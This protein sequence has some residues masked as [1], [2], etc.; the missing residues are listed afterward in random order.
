MPIDPVC[1]RDVSIANAAAS[2]D[3]HGETMYFCS[4]NC[5]HLFEQDPAE[6]M[7]DMSDEERIA[8]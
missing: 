1:K 2:H 8:S 5:L 3:F 7:D 6:Y 4:L